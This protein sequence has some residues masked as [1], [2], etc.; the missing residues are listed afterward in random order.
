MCL[1]S[2]RFF[3]VL[4]SYFTYVAINAQTLY[5]V[6]GSG[7]FNDPQHWSLSPDGPSANSIPNSSSNIY[8][9]E[10][11]SFPERNI[12][13][14]DNFHVNSI[15]IRTYQKVNLVGGLT[16]G[17]LSIR[18]KFENLPDNGNFNSEITLEFNNNFVAQTGEIKGN[19]S[20]L[21]CDFVISGGKWS[22]INSNLANAH[23]L[24]VKNASVEFR[25]STIEVGNL[26]LQ[27][28]NY[29]FFNYAYLKVRNEIK[30]ENCTNYLIKKSVIGDKRFDGLIQAPG[31]LASISG[32]VNSS[33][34]QVFFTCI[35]SSSVNTTCN[36]GC[37]GQVTIVL[38]PANC[39]SPPATLPY[40]IVVTSPGGCVDPGN[41]LTAVGPGTYVLSNF[42]SCNNGDQF[43]IQVEDANGLLFDP[44][45]VVLNTQFGN[46]PILASPASGGTSTI[47][48]NGTCSGSLNVNF[49]NGLAPYNFTITPTS[50]SPTIT[51]SSGSLALTGLCAGVLTITVRDANQCTQTYSRTFNSPAALNTNSVLTNINCNGN[52][53]GSLNLSP[54]GGSSPYV[55]AFNP[56]TTFTIGA[57]STVGSSGLCAGVVSATLTDSKSCS[58][59]TSAN[60]VS[61]PALSL[62][63]GNT[64]LSC[65]GSCNGSATIN[66]SGGTPNYN[67]T[68][69]PLVGAPIT[70]STTGVAVIGTLCAGS[71]TVNA[72]DINLCTLSQVFTVAEPPA[73]TVTPTFTNI[74]CNGN[75][76]G[77]IDVVTSG[78]NGAP[79]TYTWS[80]V[81][82][83]PGATTPTLV[84]LCANP[85]TLNVRDGALCTASVVIN[86][87]QPLP[88]TLVT[89]TQA[90]SCFGSCNGSATVTASGGNPGG[91]TYTW[92]PNPPAGQTTSV[93]TNLCGGSAF[94]VTVRD[95]SLCTQTASINI[96]NA[97]S[98]TPNITTT[99]IACH[100]LCTGA[101]N[102]A[103]TGTT[104][105]NYTLTVPGFT[106][107]AAPPYNALC[108]GIYTLFMQNTA[109]GCVQSFTTTVTEPNTL[110]GSI[111]ATNL[112][113]FNVCNGSIVGSPIG[114]TPGYTLSWVTPTGTVLGASL[115]N[116]CAGNYVL[117]ITDANGCTNN[118]LTATL[119]QPPALTVNVNATPATCA[120]NCDGILSAVVGG[121]TPGYGF[122]WSNGP[123]SN[124]NN[125][126]CAGNYNLIV[127]DANGCTSA[128][129]ATITEPA[130]ITIVSAV[131][132]VN[133]SGGFTGSATIT[134]SGGTPGFTYVFNTVPPTAPIATN[135]TGIITG[136]GQGN[137][138][139][140]ATDANGCTQ[141]INFN[142]TSPTLLTASVTG[143]VNSC[144]VCT[145]A[146]TVAIS[147]GTAPYLPASWTNSLGAVVGTGNTASS[148][149]PG[150][151]TITVTDN[152]LC[153]TTQTV[154]VDLVVNISVL[155]GGSGI[156]CFGQSTGTAVA[157]PVGGTPAYQ[158]TWT[159]SSNAVVSNTNVAS[160][161]SAGTY[162]VFVQ[163]QPG[164][165]GS[166]TINITQPA[167]VT[168]TSSQ[169]NVLCFGGLTGAI[170]VTASGGTGPLNY[171]WTPSAPNTSVLTNLAVGTYSLLIRDNNLC[172]LSLPVFTI[173]QNTPITGAF[174][175]TN[176]TACT[177]STGAVC[178]LAGGG[179]PG[180]QY[181]WTPT[182]GN[183]ACATGLVAGNYNVIIKDNANCTTTLAALLSNPT[184]PTLTINSQSINCFGGATGAITVTAAGLSPFSFSWTPVVAA[185]NNATSSIAS[186]LS[187]GI[188]QVSAA[189]NNS[190]VTTQTI[191]I[192]S[193]PSITTNAVVSD[194]KCN[195]AS[196]GS[197]V[198]TPAGGTP[199]YSF[200]W[201]GGLP[202][203]G[204]VTGLGAGIYS[205]TITDG[206]LCSTNFTFNVNEPTA[207]T[208]ATTSTNVRCN[209][210]CNGSIVATASGGLGPVSYNWL[211]VGSFAGAI[212]PTILNLCPNVYTVIASNPNCSVVATV[213]ITEP[214]AMTSTLILL[215]ATCSN[216]CNAIATHS[217][218]GGVPGYNYSW[219]LGPSTASVLSG[220]CPGNYIAAASDANGCIIL[221]TFTVSSPSTFTVAL[222]ATDPKC[223]ASCDGSITT[224]VS[225]AQGSVNYNWA[226]TGSGQNPTGLCPGTYTLIATDANFCV[227]SG[228][229]TL[230]N[231]PLLLANVSTTNASCASSCNGMVNST[232]VNA[233][234]PV[235]YV[236]TPAAPNTPNLTNVCS[237]Q[238]TLQITDNNGCQATQQF[239]LTDPPLLIVNPSTIPSTC[240]NSNG[241][242]TANVIGGTPAYSFNWPPPVSS[243]NSVVSG[244][245][246]GIYTVIVS[247]A[248]NCTNTITVPLSNSDGPNFVPIVS[249]SIACNGLCTG[250][251]SVDIAGITGGTPGY[252]VTW[253]APAP[254]STNPINNL[255]AGGYT[256]QV[257]DA[258]NCVLFT[259]VTIL[260]P[261]AINLSPSFGL[262]TCN[263]TCDGS[264]SLNPTG[265]VGPGYTYTWLP[266]GPPNSPV[267]TN[268]CAGNYNVLIGDNGNNCVYSQTVTLPSQLNIIVST[269][270]VPNQCF[271]DCNAS[272]T[273][274]NPQGGVA[275]Y[276]F[277]WSNGQVGP[278]AN[279]LCNGTYTLTI[280]DAN[281]CFSSFP[282]V[283]TSAS[284][285]TSTVSV[286]SPSCGLCNGASDIVLAGGVAP[287]TYTW[288]T[289]ANT[290]SI[291]NAC[292]GIYQVVVR[293]ALNCQQ[294]ETVIINNSNG[295]TGETFSI[296]PLPC[297]GLCAG[298][299]TV[300]AVGGNAPV[301]YNWVN[302]VSTSSAITNLCAG[303]YFVQMT[304]A[305]GCLRTASVNIDPLTTLTIS[306]FISPPGCGLSDGVISV[307]INGGALPYTVSWNPPSGS[308]ATLTGI[309]QGS[310]TITVT[311]NGPNAC[312][313]SQQ[314]NVS[315]TTG[316]VLNVT[317]TDINCFNTCTGSLS[318]TASGSPGPFSFNWSNGS[319]AS[320][321]T[322][323][324]KGVLTLTVTDNTTNCVTIETYTINENPQMQS[325]TPQITQPSCGLCN[326]SANLNVFGGSP[327]YSYT[328]STGST[329]PNVVGLCAGLYQVHVQD[330]FGCQLSQTV[331]I[332]NSNGITGETFSVQGLP[333]S[334]T[335][336]GSATVSAQGGNGAITYNWISPAVTN[337]VISN[338]CAGD[339]FVQMQD[340]QGCIRTASVSVDAVTTLSIA[341][342]IIQPGCGL[343]NGSASV[344]ISGGTPTYAV[345]WS[346]G[347][348]TT[349]TLSNIFQGS[350]TVTVTE[351][352]PNK[353]SLTQQINVSNLSGP[354]IT[355]TQ[356]DVAC[357]GQCTGIIDAVATGTS[358]PFAYN[359]SVGGNSPVITNLCQ[360]VITLSV[361][362]ASNCVTIESYTINDHPPLQWGLPQITEPTCNQCNGLATIN[363][364]G[365]SLPYTLLWTNG[366]NSAAATDL[367]AGVYQVQITDALGCQATENVIVN[368]ATGITDETFNVQDE[369]CSNSCNGSATVTAI[370]GVLPISYNW[371]N[372]AVSGQIIG[373][374]CPGDYFVQMTD[375]N[376]CIRTSSTTVN[377]IPGFTF[378]PQVILPS[379]GNS[380]GSID[381]TVIGGTLPY[382]YLWSPVAGNTP[383]LT[384]IG[385]GTYSL[386]ITD[387]TNCS[388]TQ[389]FTISSATAPAVTY[390]QSNIN[391]FNA[392][393]GAIDVV[394]SGSVAPFTYS[395]SVG[396]VTTP[397][398]TGLCKGLVTLTV[399]SSNGCVNIRSFTVTESPELVMGL[400]NFKSPGCFGDCNGAIT[401]V[402]NG[403]VLPYTYSWQPS[404]NSN[405]LTALCAGIYSVTLTDVKG[406][407]KTSTV[408]LNN[409]AAITVTV[410]PGNSSCGSVADGSIGIVVSGGTP[411]YT[412]AWAGPSA[413]TSTSQNITDLFSGSY[414]LTLFD[415]AGCTG[416]TILTLAPTI[417]ISANAGRDTIV[418]VGNEVVLSG[419]N[420]QG[421]VTYNW[422]QLPDNTTTV[423]AAPSFTLPVSVNSVTFELVTVSSVPGCLDRDTV[424]VSAYPELLVD[425]GPSVIIPVFSSVT[426]GGNPTSFSAISLTWSPAI[427]LNDATSQNPVASNTLNVIY[428]VTAVDANGCTAND[429][430]LVELYP[431]VKI[432]NGFSPNGDGKNDEWIIDYIEQF[433]NNTVEVYNRWGEQLF[434]SQGYTTPFNGKY[435]GKDLPVGTYY[436]IIHLN[437]PA[438]TK[439]YTG[440][441]TIF[442]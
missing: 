441:L 393:T 385:P 37:D 325:G 100:G 416:D 395:W 141:G 355:T 300:S 120:G 85:Y 432:A 371:I 184:G 12:I 115:L 314:I 183:A 201:S 377:T 256:A 233:T 390:T 145:G 323:L 4:V 60:L 403:G 228:V 208:L 162:V 378:T 142:I 301:S 295:I 146:A 186:G 21:N 176:P 424:V 114:G 140:S 262:P 276:N 364:F 413:F 135:T 439:P 394:V 20:A 240:N 321:L 15:T 243:T 273:A 369:Q 117:H 211:P 73:V 56:G 420:S 406:C 175:S 418:C 285:I 122:S 89:A 16:K 90:L 333:C 272:A 396:G 359:W 388:K 177:F 430:M 160:G 263:G 74:V 373:N 119:T 203:S 335:C 422:Y 150:N 372:P 18:S 366:A 261:P 69:V 50:G 237:G 138:L 387:G 48:C 221:K 23:G 298:A 404:G 11:V 36:P 224:V 374:L 370:G 134:A 188:Y 312:A 1:R 284:D 318:V 83:F 212:T 31:G 143:I 46:P 401:L 157:N 133:C 7:N 103:P 269:S 303:T 196:N 96:L 25:F 158:Y 351:S 384:G 226:L 244:L 255:C 381:V 391:C 431:E 17:V 242:I 310:Y 383:S 281:G 38:P 105:F 306:A 360:G 338:L 361:T 339:Y 155:A 124:P 13:V 169:T 202:N 435:R 326:G 57:G 51:T 434:H 22:I 27:D 291:T 68:V 53:T 30:I 28:C 236:W 137:Y 311:E 342:T 84:N 253:L 392:C 279:N 309:S 329:G 428:T 260:E 405:P 39:F 313:Q 270:I 421:A 375:G 159:N 414:S 356:T 163:D 128:V 77:A 235:T 283:I 106:S 271:N 246:A 82:A 198:V 180:Y 218:G 104:P 345:S 40:N 112:N 75:C 32:K 61:P 206:A 308:S 200:V 225:G 107:T 292:A 245:V 179:S 153:V 415:N 173:T 99:N 382:T 322:N 286:T 123:I 337:S 380:D 398:I 55:V 254:S 58:V 239:T 412:F 307:D 287:Y 33:P 194:V 70:G 80:P 213:Q 230:N 354:V 66:L 268:A 305:Q 41:G 34:N 161:L 45:A 264:I 144:N 386:L 302:P 116:Q 197:I 234:G 204:T 265:G 294:T 349:P 348:N 178:V 352:G 172:A 316:P 248:N 379:C 423:S 297:S 376:G 190:C 249:T 209:G 429:T 132:N 417:T 126:L 251:A 402:P 199:A 63:V 182:G 219:S 280:T 334:G 108:A 147:G 95:V 275:P 187:A 319:T 94:V 330:V 192:A 229:V 110:S 317:Q 214:P 193:A 400:P 419:S 304:D 315:N 149:C 207:L 166:A 189:D 407:Q 174:T 6:G 8:F 399:T 282:V 72:R 165:L 91:Y 357:F 426:I 427:Y 299:V 216:S 232:P 250:A 156:A 362:D 79:Y 327:A 223:N 353:C 88:L 47:S 191:N 252:N 332:N 358:A 442:R 78:G 101:I 130:P 436:Y 76:N 167:S 346:P 59:T 238:Y 151:Y 129:T 336:N 409:P 44:T 231:P 65:N 43:S 71:Y 35:T 14:S 102:A 170:S 139:V 241:G 389:V 365:G 9:E 266:S 289:G 93:I 62:T 274:F 328:W 111:V 164:C 10:S 331:I 259:G 154:F 293:D 367:C 397:S 87:T 324:C 440:P 217:V 410:T 433:P 247:D 222:T 350:Y 343:N 118:T 64:S 258:N 2:K 210:A 220:L 347:S 288:T 344:F 113:C 278:T 92:S 125:N 29:L 42:C 109:T 26:D 290:S 227:T 363:V 121:G 425:A 215:N 205:L 127:T 168:A 136:L 86:L 195:G 98:F 181:T 368:N 171:S 97:P 49:F 3:L 267:I 24:Y 408:E 152:N 320:A 52:C 340:E 438:Y 81:G 296:Q 148:L 411:S 131:T 437:H 185:V 257:T 5:W 54:T 341:T 19:N 67:Y 277:N